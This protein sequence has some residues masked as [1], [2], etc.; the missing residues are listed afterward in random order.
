MRVIV[1]L[2]FSLFSFNLLSEEYLC[3]GII[4]DKTQIKTYE[5]KGDYFL[6]TTQGWDFKILHEDEIHIMLGKISYYQSLE[7]TTLFL[8]IIDKD[9]LNFTERFITSEINTVSLL[10]GN[11][12]L[13]R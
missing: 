3:S 7:E 13:K 9:T 8:T 12:L 10:K 1:F 2:I 11:C 6:Y 5:R 4:G